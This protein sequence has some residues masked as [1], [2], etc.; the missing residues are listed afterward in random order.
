MIRVLCLLYGLFAYLIS[1]TTLLYLVGFV[2]DYY[3]PKSINSGAQTPFITAL[4]INFGL[5]IIFI[6]QHLI[7]A[8]E[9]FRLRLTKVIPVS[10]ERSTFV[11]ASSLTLI[12]LLWQWRP[13]PTLV[14]DLGDGN[15]SLFF[16]LAAL[17]GWLFGIYST[18][19][20][21]HFQ[22]FGIRQVYYFFRNMEAPPI[23]FKIRG[24][25]KYVRYPVMLG[26]LIAF[27]STSRMSTGHLLF[28]ATMSIFIFIG[29]F[30]KEREFQQRHPKKFQ[31]YKR[32]VHM[33]VPLPP[34]KK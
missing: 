32:R 28:S 26:F 8:R 4:A 16:K 2:F 11:L 14:W 23:Y 21:N 3:V 17:G 12:F 10:I 13:L 15:V 18:F 34:G 19:M 20:I 6:S 1:I 25:Y 24:P 22:L 30:Q 27:W 29:I 31:A 7:M 9:S 5:I 33:I